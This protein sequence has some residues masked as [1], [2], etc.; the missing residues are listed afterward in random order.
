MRRI[1]RFGQHY[2]F[3]TNR[4]AIYDSMWV[5]DYYVWTPKGG[6]YLGCTINESKLD[7]YTE[8]V[9]NDQRETSY[10]KM[11]LGSIVKTF[12]DVYN[13]YKSDVNY[14]SNWNLV[15]DQ[16]SDVINYN[17]SSNLQSAK[18]LSSINL[19]YGISWGFTQE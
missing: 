6:Y 12:D 5:W 19:N 16:K 17:I 18:E 14:D 11:E 13:M 9:V 15:Q 3:I 10:Q 7:M 8:D 2:P 1:R 4:V